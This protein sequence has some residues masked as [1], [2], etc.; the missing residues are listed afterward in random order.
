[1]RW[2]SPAPSRRMEPWNC[3]LIET[4]G[5]SREKP[6][7]IRDLKHFLA[8]QLEALLTVRSAIPGVHQKTGRDTP[9]LTADR[10]G[11]LHTAGFS[12]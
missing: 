12:E 8:N 10:V 2:C 11:P 5:K 4:V 1:M 3:E 7:V 9:R 6:L